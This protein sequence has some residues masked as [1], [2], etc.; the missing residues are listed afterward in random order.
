MRSTSHKNIL[1]TSQEVYLTAIDTYYST[2]AVHL[3]SV[4]QVTQALPQSIGLTNFKSIR[5]LRLDRCWRL[6]DIAEHMPDLTTLYLTN[7]LHDFYAQGISRTDSR[8][9]SNAFRE[10]VRDPSADHFPGVEA[11]MH[12]LPNLSVTGKATVRALFFD[13]INAPTSSITTANM[14]FETVSLVLLIT[15]GVTA[16]STVVEYEH[17][18]QPRF[19]HKFEIREVPMKQCV[20]RGHGSIAY[21]KAVQIE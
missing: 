18:L 17:R 6:R 8:R 13:L 7:S 21:S 15:T 11:L 9:D 10:I 12:K 5:K 19:V 20:H 14:A 1:R 16:N 3:Q 2:I 4:H